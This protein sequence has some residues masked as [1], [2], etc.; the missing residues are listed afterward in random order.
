MLSILHEKTVSH[1]GNIRASEF[2]M[3]MTSVA[4]EPY[5][6]IL[7]QWISGGLIFDE[8]KEFFIEDN[9]GGE[10]HLPGVNDDFYW[11]NRYETVSNKIPI[12]LARLVDKILRTGMYLTVIRECGNDIETTSNPEPLQYTTEERVY[13]ERIGVAYQYA[14]KKI[15]RIL[16]DESN[17][18]AHLNSV[19][20]YFFMDKG[21]F[22]VL[23][24]DI[25]ENELKK[26]IDSIVPTRLQSLLELAVRTSAMSQDPH[27]DL[28]GI[29]L[30]PDS[31]CHQLS[32]ILGHGEEDSESNFSDSTKGYEALALRYKVEWPLSLILNQRNIGRY[33]ML[34]RHLFY[35][36][37]VERQLG[38]TWKDS[39]I[40]KHFALRAIKTYAEAFGLRQKMLNFVQNLEYYM[41]VEVIEPNFHN[42]IQ[43]VKE[44]EGKVNSI[45]DMITEHT[46]FMDE[47]LQDCMLTQ[48]RAL[49][50][51]VR[52]LDLCMEFS[53][54]MHV[55]MIMGIF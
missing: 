43:K 55:S 38:T 31:V 46:I 19:K 32:R 25:A 54:F 47:C 17:L 8:Y 4:C 20:H 33:Q 45:D 14:S 37:Y 16:L 23:F 36:K 7:E 22:I 42:F 51:M 27:A 12:F 44:K 11:E 5:F 13:A 6:R 34:F 18:V 26:D 24:M 9:G 29:D 52:L 2:C 50:L 35:C 15:L 1:L 21:D 41:M 53:E 39:K 10:E 40:S 28:L 48:K 3:K 30:L 49:K